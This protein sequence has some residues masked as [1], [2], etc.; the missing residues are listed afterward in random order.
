MLDHGAK[1]LKM[2]IRTGT[3]VRMSPPVYNGLTARV[4]FDPAGFWYG[5]VRSS[6]DRLG[7]ENRSP[8]LGN[9]I[10]Q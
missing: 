10:I 3:L 9:F 8:G 2:N 4:A 6:L 5:R 1:K 7:P